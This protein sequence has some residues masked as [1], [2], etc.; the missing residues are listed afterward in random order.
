[1]AHPI[2]TGARQ[3]GP[4]PGPGAPGGAPPALCPPKTYRELLTDEANSP[5]PGRLA[6]YLQGYRF[7]GPGDIPAPATLRDQTVT[8]SDRQPMTFLCLVA[9]PP[10]VSIVHR[11]MRYMDIAG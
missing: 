5:A 8:V 3:E 11:L 4:P 1:M 7:D 2:P 6:E 10:E 9:G